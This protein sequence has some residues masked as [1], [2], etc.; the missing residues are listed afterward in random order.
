MPQIVDGKI[1]QS[2]TLT[3]LRTDPRFRD[4]SD[5]TSNGAGG[6][7]IRR[8][9]LDGAFMVPKTVQVNRLTV[10]KHVQT[11]SLQ[12]VAGSTS[13]YVNTF[14]VTTSFADLATVIDQYA[15]NALRT[16]LNGAQA[17]GATGV[18]LD[19]PDVGFRAGQ[20]IVIDSGENAE[21]VTIARALCTPPVLKTTITVPASAGAT[22]IRLASYSPEVLS[23]ANAPTNN[24]PI[25][26]QPIVLDTGANQEVVSVKRHLSRLPAAPAPNVELSAPLAKD[27]AA[28]T[29]T[30]LNNV[31][32][33]APLTKAHATDVAVANPQPLVTA[34]K[35]TELRT[36]L[37]DATA[38]A[39]AGDTAGAIAALQAFNAAA[40]VPAADPERR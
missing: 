1:L 31:I 38:K 2:Q 30:N 27:H 36:L 6:S 39:G 34:A 4:A 11:A 29:A 28:G 24:G 20:E 40:A 21:T 9:T 7:A 12:D 3:P 8:M 15:D 10:G 14:V 26:G 13:K 37:A 19:E 32:L 17:V 35:A 16:T 22:Q 18:R 23:G 33:A 5:T 25:I